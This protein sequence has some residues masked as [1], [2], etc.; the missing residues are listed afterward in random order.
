M[1]VHVGGAER[2]QL[3]EP[4]GCEKVSLVDDDQ[5]APASLELL[6]G[7]QVGGLGH[8]LGL[9]EA[10]LCAEGG[11]EGDVDLAGAEGGRVGEVDDLVGGRVELADGGAEGDG[12]ADADLAGDD[13]EQALGDT[14]ADA[15]DGFVVSGAREEIA[16]SDVLAEGHAGEAEA[17]GPAG[18]T[19]GRFSSA[20]SPSRRR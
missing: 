20:S 18:D 8:D 7:E 2:A 9:E 6:G 13:A 19:H 4:G 14:E 16:S 11:D 3:L 12:L 10:G 15:G 1:G 5:H 17:L